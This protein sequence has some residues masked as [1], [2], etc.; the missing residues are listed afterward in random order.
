MPKHD[1]TLRE[2]KKKIQDD[3][4]NRL[5]GSTEAPSDKELAKTV[6]G[7]LR[8]YEESYNL[9]MQDA[10]RKEFV[11]NMVNDFAHLGPLED[12]LAHPG[13]TEIMVNGAD[14]VFVEMDGKLVE[15]E[16]AFEDNDHV[17]RIIDKIV[18]GVNR[19]IDENQPYVDARL[20]DGS[21]VNATIPP[22]SMDYPTITIRRFSDEKLTWDD[23]LDWGSISDDMIDFLAGAVRARCNI[24]VIGGTGSGKSTLL[25]V[26][27]NEIQKDQRIVTIEDS[28][29]LKLQQPHVVR[30]ETRQSNAEGAGTVTMHD[31]LVNA[32]RMRPDRIIVGECRSGEALEMLQAMNTGHDGSLTTI[33]ANDPTGAFERL[34]TMVMYASSLPEKA[35]KRQIAQAIDLVV[36]TSRMLDGTRKVTAIEAVANNLEGEV[37]THVPVFRFVQEGIKKGH[38]VGHFEGC[39]TPTDN[40]IQKFQSAGETMD[41]MWFRKSASEMKE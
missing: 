40:V 30:F 31:I 18:Q 11:R 39:G 16:S 26:I 35:I 34:I 41:P 37:I 32:L 25:N 1:A 4:Q 15:V 20:D 28:A 6:S 14:Q 17:R 36:E 22:V 29:E 38:V 19:R 13:I 7:F 3:L 24:L 27:S 9:A 23:Y 8:R 12:L 2:I 21:R 5:V 33:H 10:E